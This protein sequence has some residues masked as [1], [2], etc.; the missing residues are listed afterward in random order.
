[1][2][3]NISFNCFSYVGWCKVCAQN[4]RSVLT[5]FVSI[6]NLRRDSTK[7]SLCKECKETDARRAQSST[8]ILT[9]R[10]DMVQGVHRSD[11]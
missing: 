6:L 1:V 7:L 4:A 11:I 9:L 5:G 2:N 10:K 8:R 3:V